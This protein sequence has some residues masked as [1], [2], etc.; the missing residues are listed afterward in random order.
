M[1]R[2]CEMKSTLS[3]TELLWVRMLYHSDR[4]EL[5]QPLSNK[6]SMVISQL[7]FRIIMLSGRSQAPFSLRTVC[8]SV[9]IMPA[10]ASLPVPMEKAKER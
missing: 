3:F 2:K 9:Y 1:T 5:G 7:N 6:M 10:R 4:T 8:D